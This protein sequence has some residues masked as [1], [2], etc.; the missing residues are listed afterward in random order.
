MGATLSF[1]NDFAKGHV[2]MIN[3]DWLGF[4]IASVAVVLAP[5][6]GSLFVAKTAATA[7]ARAGLL[8]M[9][10]IM[11][12]DGCLIVLS[13]LGVSALF[14]AHPALFQAIRLAGAG[15]LIFV[16]LQAIFAKPAQ[17]SGLDRSHGIPFR[18]AVAIT[19]LNPKAVLFFMA[20]FP[21]FINSAEDSLVLSYATMALVFMAISATYLTFLVHASSMLATGFRQNPALQSV[22]RKLCGCVFIG[23]G[24]KVAASSR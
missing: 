20:F 22:A 2:R 15:Y 18:Q 14:L 11:I 16:G 21:M 23:F 4:T 24:L 1:W 10:G 5:G 8:A 12:G 9:L 7:C 3:V 17:D 19:L 6:P 13:L